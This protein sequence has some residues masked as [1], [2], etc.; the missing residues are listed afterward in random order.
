MNKLPT[1]VNAI[2]AA[3]VIAGGSGLVLTRVN[4][5]E[6]KD[7]KEQQ[8]AAN[9]AQIRI[10]EDISSLKKGVEK[11]EERQKEDRQERRAAEQRHDDKL[12]ELLR[13]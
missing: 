3:A 7:I 10:R 6:L 13:K 8:A 12:D 4:A 1:W 11:I 2:I 9:A 5:A